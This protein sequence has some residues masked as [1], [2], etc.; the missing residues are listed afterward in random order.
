MNFEIYDLLL[1][2]SPVLDINI[3]I[4]SNDC[5]V[6]RQ[7]TKA[8]IYPTYI[9]EFNTLQSLLIVFYGYELR[10]VCIGKQCGWHYRGVGDA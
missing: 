1:G 10:N 2:K 8:K 6:R 7:E 5:V 4:N 9:S 3:A